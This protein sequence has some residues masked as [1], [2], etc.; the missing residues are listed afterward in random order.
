MC[1]ITDRQKGV[2]YAIWKHRTKP[3]AAATAMGFLLAPNRHD[4]NHSFNEWL[5]KNLKEKSKPPVLY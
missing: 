1:Y 5:I 3:I 2:K 4:K